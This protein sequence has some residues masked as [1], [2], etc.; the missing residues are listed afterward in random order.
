MSSNTL[1]VLESHSHKGIHLSQTKYIGDL[2]KKAQM[3]E[4]KGCQ[5]PKSST[6]KLVKNKGAAFENPF[7][8][9]SIVGSWILAICDLNQA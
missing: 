5:T 9:M 1:L 8:Y 6:E 7:L 4:S 3:L 2:L